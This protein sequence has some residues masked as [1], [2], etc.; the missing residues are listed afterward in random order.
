MFGHV[1]P[2]VTGRSRY[3]R[4]LCSACS[5]EPYSARPC[6]L[7]L[8]TGGPALSKDHEGPPR[9]PLPALAQVFSFWYPLW[10]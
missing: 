6:G 1:T 9:I 2:A 5:P 3:L 4:P 8:G 7:T 10:K